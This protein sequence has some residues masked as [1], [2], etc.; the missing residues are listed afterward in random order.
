MLP[1]PGVLEGVKVLEIVTTITKDNK[2]F[3][4]EN[5]SSPPNPLSM[6]PTA[7]TP[8]PT[9]APAPLPS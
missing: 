8:T 3:L 5:G 6:P 2:Q 1:V 4:G 9:P 7:P